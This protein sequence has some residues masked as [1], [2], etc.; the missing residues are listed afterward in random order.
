MSM[1]SDSWSRFLRRAAFNH[2]LAASV[3]EAPKIDL[4]G[5]LLLWAVL[6]YLSDVSKL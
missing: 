6:H 4:L 2:G 1:I 5:I 3:N